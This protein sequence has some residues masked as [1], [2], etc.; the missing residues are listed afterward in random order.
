MRLRN[1]SLITL[2]VALFMLP[3]C[4]GGSSGGGS[5]P[6]AKNG[7]VL[8]RGLMQQGRSQFAAVKLDSGRVLLV[9]G[10]GS[11]QS[12]DLSTGEVY[13]PV[14]DSFPR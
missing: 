11:L 13:D 9:G 10:L 2:I 12:T 3:A 8:T 4:G 7:A 14:K 6:K 1:A 5:T